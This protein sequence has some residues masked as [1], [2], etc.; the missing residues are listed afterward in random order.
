[1]SSNVDFKPCF[2]SGLAGPLETQGSARDSSRNSNLEQ[3]ASLK[4][5]IADE[6]GQ[7]MVEWV[8]ISGLMVAVLAA[9]F[10]VFPTIISGFYTQGAVLLCL[11]IF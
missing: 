8:I 5:I 4:A 9:T 6:G 2:S 1:M 11:P 7:A 10:A 3:T